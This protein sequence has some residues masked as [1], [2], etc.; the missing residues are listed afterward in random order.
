MFIMQG[1]PFT[2]VHAQLPGLPTNAPQYILEP[3]AAD[4]EPL[5]GSSGMP[6]ELGPAYDP[7]CFLEVVR[8]VG[9]GAS[10][11]FV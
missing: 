4:L 7:R 10:L 8:Q 11:K 3:A 1:T 5:P 6:P 9:A 2:V